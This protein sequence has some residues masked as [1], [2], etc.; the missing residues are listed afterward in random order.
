MGKG[1]RNCIKMT[2]RSI[3]GP[4]LKSAV[5]CDWDGSESDSSAVQRRSVNV[6][7][8]FFIDFGGLCTHH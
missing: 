6:A 5:R 8:V 4:G 7:L 3:T 1:C 2:E